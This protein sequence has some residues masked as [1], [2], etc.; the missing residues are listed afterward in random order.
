MGNRT[1]LANILQHKIDTTQPFFLW[2]ID[3]DH[4]GQVIKLEH[5]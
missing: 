2:L 4:W 1:Y 5:K 3:L